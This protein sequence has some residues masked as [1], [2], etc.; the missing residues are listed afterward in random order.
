MLYIFPRLSP[1]SFEEAEARAE[2]LSM[3][4]VASGSRKDIQFLATPFVIWEGTAWIRVRSRHLRQ[5]LYFV[6]STDPRK[7][8]TNLH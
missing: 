1:S 4:A 2:T 5:H 8:E 7:T 6:L 3:A